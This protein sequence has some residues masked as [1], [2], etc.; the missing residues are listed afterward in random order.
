L[1]HTGKTPSVPGIPDYSIAGMS[2]NSPK[3]LSNYRR[4]LAVRKGR[5]L[6]IMSCLGII[7]DNFESKLVILP[8]NS[9]IQK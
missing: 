6:E 4:E 2:V 8:E 3:E 9:C 7:L 5:R 1:K